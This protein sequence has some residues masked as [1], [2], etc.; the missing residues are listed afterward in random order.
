MTNPDYAAQSSRQG[1]AFDPQFGVFGVDE[2][3]NADIIPEMVREN[4]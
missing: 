1:P 3:P 4:L 2:T